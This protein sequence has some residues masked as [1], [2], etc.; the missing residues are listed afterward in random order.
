MFSPAM[1]LP[2]G[3]PNTK[4][5]LGCFLRRVAFLPNGLGGELS[6]KVL[7]LV[8]IP[9][10]RTLAEAQEIRLLLGCPRQRERPPLIR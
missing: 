3:P 7:S 8:S 9:P 1:H 5:F 4:F 2:P 10:S 6:N